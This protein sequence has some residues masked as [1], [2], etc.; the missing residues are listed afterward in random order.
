MAE[1]AH[2]ARPYAR[3]VFELARE[4]KDLAGWGGALDLFAAIV[5]DENMAALINNPRVPSAQ[6][7]DAILETAAK[8]SKT[9][10]EKL[11]KHSVNL[12]KLLARNGRLHALPAVARAYA[13]L[14]AEAESV[15][16]VRITSA[17]EIA[18]PQRKEL[19][20]ALREKLGRK[21]ELEYAADPELVGGA[22]VR[23]G[24][25]VVDGSVRA[26]LQQLASAL[27]A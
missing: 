17:A 21:I 20:S 27:G 16:A 3:A 24:D 13:D 18:P 12:I 19:E 10:V 5:A 8:F 26:Q 1:T 9:S 14:R 23:I 25:S 15:V 22:V 11:D 7:Q 2:L 6:L 4:K